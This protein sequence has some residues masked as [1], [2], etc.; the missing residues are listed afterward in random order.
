M[1]L[2]AEVTKFRD[3][4]AGEAQDYGE[5]ETA[6]DEWHNL[7]SAVE[8]I[9]YKPTLDESEVQLLLYALAR[10]NECEF[11][12]GMLEDYPEHGLRLAAAAVTYPEYEARWQA[13]DFLGRIETLEAKE[14]L[15]RFVEDSDEYVR[16]RALLAAQEHDPTFAE[17]VARHWVE[18]PLY[19]K[20]TDKS[21]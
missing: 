16:R 13:A 8:A 14:L 4:A 12:R 2:E 20:Q 9:L 1:S 3:W 10:D 7:Y 17:E 18:S 11:I 19:P 5:W 21:H 15:R 6:Y